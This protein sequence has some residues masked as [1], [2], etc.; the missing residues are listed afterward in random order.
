MGTGGLLHDP[1]DP[2]LA[3]VRHFWKAFCTLGCCPLYKYGRCNTWKFT[4]WVFGLR[5]KG[6]ARTQIFF[7]VCFVFC[8][9]LTGLKAM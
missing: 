5:L 8:F 2:K 7:C 9:L 1:A 6:F 3:S 4:I